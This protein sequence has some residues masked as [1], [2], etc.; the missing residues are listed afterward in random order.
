M[1]GTRLSQ[2]TCL[3]TQPFLPFLCLSHHALPPFSSCPSSL[4]WCPPHPSTVRA[5]LIAFFCPAS[6]PI[7]T[8]LPLCFPSLASL[9]LSLKT[10][11][12]LFSSSLH[13]HSLSSSPPLHTFRVFNGDVFKL[14]AFSAVSLCS[15]FFKII[16]FSNSHFYS[17][18]LCE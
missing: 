6:H 17:C 1:T 13:L 4:P 3:T 10:P 7:L 14:Q 12:I 9:P 15:C 8:L 18:S 16:S 11:F 2:S 5:P